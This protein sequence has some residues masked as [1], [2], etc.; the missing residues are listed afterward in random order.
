MVQIPFINS[1][2]CSKLWLKMA[3]WILIWSLAW[4]QQCECVWI[5]YL[6]SPHNS[7]PHFLLMISLVMSCFTGPATMCQV[8]GQLQ[9]SSQP[10]HQ[11]DNLSSKAASS[12]VGTELVQTNR[13]HAWVA[14]IVLKLKHIGRVYSYHAAGA[15]ILMS[16][17]LLQQWCDPCCGNLQSCAQLVTML[18]VQMCFFDPFSL[19][20]MREIGVVQ[21]SVLPPMSYNFQSVLFNAF[22]MSHKLSVK[23]MQ[24]AQCK[25]NAECICNVSAADGSFKLCLR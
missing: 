9:H 6:F 8:P 2:V 4:Y 5:K 22:N 7:L 19:D 23:Y 13:I 15:H 20:K 16:F 25:Q 3:S 24:S 10:G 12:L 18:H 1:T 17:P 21:Q 11:L 14:T